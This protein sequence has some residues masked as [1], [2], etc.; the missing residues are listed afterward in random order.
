MEKLRFYF[1]GLLAMAL[2][3]PLGMVQ[4]ELIMYM[5]LD[6]NYD[7]FEGR[8]TTDVVNG[9]F[10]SDAPPVGGNLK[11]CTTCGGRGNGQR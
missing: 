3:L 1:L 7:E 10:S 2:L 8:Y 11:K 9:A 6:G 4:A 5:P